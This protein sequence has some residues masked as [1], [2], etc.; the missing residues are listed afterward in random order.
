[1]AVW[2]SSRLLEGEMPRWMELKRLYY[3]AEAD[4][5]V[6]REWEEAEPQ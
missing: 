6:R 4:P 5:G 2:A 1:M 3:P